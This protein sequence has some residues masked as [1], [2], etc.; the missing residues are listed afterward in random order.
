MFYQG[1]TY[2]ISTSP[3]SDFWER[4]F[5]M[6]VE[7]GMNVVKH[8]AVWE[9][10]ELEDGVFDFGEI[11]SLMRTTEKYPLD[12]IIEL[13]LKNQGFPRWFFEKFPESR[14]ITA[15]GSWRASGACYNHP[16]YQ[17]Y[18]VRF[19]SRMAEELKKYRSIKVWD[20]WNEPHLHGIGDPGNSPATQQCYCQYCQDGFRSWL[21]KNPQYR[22]TISGDGWQGINTAGMGYSPDYRYRLY[23]INE[24]MVNEARRLV[25]AVRSIDSRPVALH[26]AFASPCFKM[27]TIG[28]DDWQLAKCVDVY[29][30]TSGGP[31]QMGTDW[32]RRFYSFTPLVLDETRGAA[33]GRPW[34]VSEWHVTG[35]VFGFSKRINRDFEEIK[36]EYFEALARGAGGMVTWSYRNFSNVFCLVDIRNRN[37]STYDHI[38]KIGKKLREIEHFRPMPIRKAEAAI[39]FDP[40]NFLKYWEFSGESEWMNCCNEGIYRYLYDSDV[41]VDWIHPLTLDKLENYRTVFIP[42]P[43]FLSAESLG[44]LKDYVENGGT[45]V[46]EGFFS[47][48]DGLAY[49]RAGG[50]P[51]GFDK[52]FGVQVD[53]ISDPAYSNR[54]HQTQLMHEDGMNL[55]LHYSHNSEELVPT[56]AQVLLRN[57]SGAAIVTENGFGRGR[58][59]L[60]GA[61]F[62]AQVMGS[63]VKAYAEAGALTFDGKIDSQTDTV[64]NYELLDFL[65]G[66]I[67]WIFDKP[68]GVRIDKF[69]D[70][71][72]VTNES[73]EEF[74]YRPDKPGVEIFTGERASASKGVPLQPKET[75]VFL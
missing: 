36:R 59:I 42:A 54:Q 29:G 14:P 17:E 30:V 13:R 25:E 58:A 24:V 63:R 26:D 19:T 21:S 11:H 12:V 43:L 57:E 49:S 47:H 23:F 46:S 44:A 35:G 72:I 20:I 48:L 1:A 69:G 73:K 51:H 68:K 10:I 50:I 65:C 34:F 37:T 38:E 74:L 28:N 7:K 53:K 62:F 15:D 60:C 71:R 18:S 41:M 16:K 39:L 31:V 4:D 40:V 67:G 45:I 55:T 27:Q 66:R 22:K 9:N 32:G 75:K 56:T 52:V 33:N 70:L 5:Q 3:S 2:Y 61:M 8:L 64:H 6:M